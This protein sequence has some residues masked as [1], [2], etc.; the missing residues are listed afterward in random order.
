MIASFEKAPMLNMPSI[1]VARRMR[2]AAPSLSTEQTVEMMPFPG[3]R[4]QCS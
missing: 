1:D 4:G 2:Y 3:T